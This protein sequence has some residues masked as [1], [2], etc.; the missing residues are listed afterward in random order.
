ME[1]HWAWW[2]L[3]LCMRVFGHGLLGWI[4]AFFLGGEGGFVG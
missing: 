4:L 2:D 3:I 1:L